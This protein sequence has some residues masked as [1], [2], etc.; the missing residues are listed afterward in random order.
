MRFLKKD[1]QHKGN[2]PNYA[3]LAHAKRQR[4]HLL[5]PDGSLRHRQIQGI[6]DRD[7]EAYHIPHGR[8][9]AVIQR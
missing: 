6:T 3:R 5:M 4:V 7:A 1:G 9:Q 2:D 8:A